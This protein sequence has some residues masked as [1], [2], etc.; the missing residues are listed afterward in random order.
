MRYPVFQFCFNYDEKGNFGLVFPNESEDFLSMTFAIPITKHEYN[1]QRISSKFYFPTVNKQESNETEIL[2][3]EFSLSAKVFEQEM[4]FEL[5]PNFLHPRLEKSKL[6][7]EKIYN[8][9][10][11]VGEF[12]QYSEQFMGFLVLK[13]PS[14]E[15]LNSLY[16]N[17]KFSFVGFTPQFGNKKWSNDR[18]K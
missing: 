12:K 5:I 2:F 13:P 17:S 4:N 16:F 11:Y 18:F 3:D 15:I 7:H 10:P 14:S 9:I 1:N 8:I 6:F